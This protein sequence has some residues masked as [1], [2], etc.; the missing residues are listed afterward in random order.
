MTPTTLNTRHFTIPQVMPPT[1]SFQFPKPL[2]YNFRVMETTKNGKVVA[3]NLQ[4]Q[5]IEHD[6]YG[7]PVTHYPWENVPRIQQEEA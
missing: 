5:R 7:A 6:E 3:V 2:S 4:V 1:Q